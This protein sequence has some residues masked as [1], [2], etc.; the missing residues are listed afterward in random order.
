MLIRREDS[1]AVR[2]T[3]QGEGFDWQDYLHIDPSRAADNHGRGIAQANVISFDELEFNTRG[4]QL[5]ASARL[6]EELEW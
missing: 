3:D 5:T 2:I 4:N 6:E 1:V